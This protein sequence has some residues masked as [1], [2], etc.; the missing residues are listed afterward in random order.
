MTRFIGVAL[1]ATMALS[2]SAATA[3]V[4]TVLYSF[5]QRTAPLARLEQLKSGALHG[6]TY[7]G[8]GLGSVFEVSERQGVWKV[9]TINAFAGSN[10]RNPIA[11]VTHDPDDV[12]WGTT[13]LGGDHNYG[14]I[15]SLTPNGTDWTPNV[16]Y[17]FT[18]GSDG[19][20]PQGNIA[21]DSVTG[22]LYGTTSF[23]GASNCGTAF[24]IS[25]AHDV[26]TLYTFHGGS[27][28]GCSPRTAMHNG[29]EAGTLL[30]STHNGGFANTGTIFELTEV[31]GVWTETVLYEFTDGIDGGFPADIAVDNNGNVVGV[32]HN[33]G[34]YGRGVLFKV[35]PQGR[36]WQETVLYNFKGAP[37]G[38]LPVGLTPGSKARTY[39]ITTEKGGSHNRGGIFKYTTSGGIGQETTLYSFGS[40]ANDGL[41]PR[42]RVNIEP[43][44]GLIY[45]TTSKGGQFGGGTVYQISE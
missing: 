35:S 30:G 14:T 40:T 28:D 3:A 44:T 13:N 23:G 19:R 37:D 15:Y 24:Q 6:T 17:S 39:Y 41:S 32:T 11:G 8:S 31:N 27:G 2:C 4:E 25:P 10:G 16:L 18:G 9:S 36:K 12:L 29:A 42:S 1:C 21:R 43:E 34:A 22:T 33:G 20:Y 38:S 7:S 45:G 26:S 5:P